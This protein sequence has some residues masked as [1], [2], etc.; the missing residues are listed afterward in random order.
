MRIANAATETGGALTV[1]AIGNGAASMQQAGRVSG[2]GAAGACA[3]FGAPQS[4]SAAATGTVAGGAL[5]ATGAASHERPASPVSTQCCEP[6]RK[7]SNAASR[8]A[9]IQ[10][11][12][13]PMSERIIVLM[14]SARGFGI[15]S[16]PAPP[17]V[18]SRQDP[19]LQRVERRV[20]P[21]ARSHT[22][23]SPGLICDAARD[24]SSQG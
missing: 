17:P 3:L 5:I 18:S 23:P 7:T 6:A 19:C 22:L 11:E 1:A 15:Q 21:D 8:A 4:C 16:A 24:R 9:R 14:L 20:A 13:R 12:S 10:P 2:R